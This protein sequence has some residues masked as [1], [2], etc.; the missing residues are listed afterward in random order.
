[1]KREQST[2]GRGAKHEEERRQETEDATDR[3]ISAAD[4][5]PET[6]SSAPSSPSVPVASNAHCDPVT[7]IVIWPYQRHPGAVVRYLLKVDSA[8]HRRIIH[9]YFI[10]SSSR[11]RVPDPEK[12]GGEVSRT[13]RKALAVPVV[14]RSDDVMS[15]DSVQAP[16]I[17]SINRI[18]FGHLL[19]SVHHSQRVPNS[20]TSSGTPVAAATVRIIFP[21]GRESGRDPHH[22]R[23]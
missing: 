21:D 20:F 19:V 8:F 12:I 23:C 17:E 11:S 4:P 16:V 18:L 22:Q 3:L 9:I 6:L 7:S 14:M 1:M 10:Y 13:W 15:H 5:T 2:E